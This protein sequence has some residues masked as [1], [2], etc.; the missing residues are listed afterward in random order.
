MSRAMIF[1]NFDWKAV[2]NTGEKKFLEPGKQAKSLN[3]PW[4]QSCRSMHTC[5]MMHTNDYDLPVVNMTAYMHAMWLMI[6][7]IDRMQ[8]FFWGV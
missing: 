2:L 3:Q 6:V 4:R 5:C 8:T 7:I 1:G